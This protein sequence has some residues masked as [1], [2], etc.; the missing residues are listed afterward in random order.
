MQISPVSP[1]LRQAPGTLSSRRTQEEN[2]KK[3]T[4][5]QLPRIQ[6]LFF[7]MHHAAAAAGAARAEDSIPR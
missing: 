7:L 6:A 5:V 1:A 4:R 2:T 3:V